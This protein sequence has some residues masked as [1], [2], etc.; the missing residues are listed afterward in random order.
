M[1][2]RE[3]SWISG[4]F[5]QQEVR[6]IHGVPGTNYLKGFHEDHNGRKWTKFTRL[7]QAVFCNGGDVGMIRNPE[8]V[9][10]EVLEVD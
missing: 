8:I 4:M 6:E 7:A 1:F 2:A 5:T 10:E 9:S 3:S